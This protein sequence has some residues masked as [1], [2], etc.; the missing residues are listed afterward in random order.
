MKTNVFELNSHKDINANTLRETLFWVQKLEL[1]IACFCYHRNPTVVS[2]L[3]T[4][5]LFKFMVF[6][7]ISLRTNDF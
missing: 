1:L 3:L 4:Q 2:K 5:K 6:D 7:S